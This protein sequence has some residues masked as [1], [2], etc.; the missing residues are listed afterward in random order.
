MNCD[1]I[2]QVNFPIAFFTLCVCIALFYFTRITTSRKHSPNDAHLEKKHE[3]IIQN[4]EEFVQQQYNKCTVES[5]HGNPAHSA[6][7]LN[8]AVSFILRHYLQTEKEVI[9]SNVHKL[10]EESVKL[11]YLPSDSKSK[12]SDSSDASSVL[13][14]FDA[15]DLKLSSRYCNSLLYGLFSPHYK[16]KSL[17]I[18]QLKLRQNSRLNTHI[19]PPVPAEKGVYFSKIELGQCFP[20]IEKIES[21]NLAIENLCFTGSSKSFHM[22]T[23]DQL[24]NEDC[25]AYLFT[26]ALNTDEN[27]CVE[28]SANVPIQDIVAL[29]FSF[30]LN[31]LCCGLTLSLVIAPGQKTN[32][33]LAFGLR[34]NGVPKV[35]F[36]LNTK[37]G[38]A[39]SI[40]NNAKVEALLRSSLSKILSEKHLDPL[41]YLYP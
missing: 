33:P 34:I 21:E 14:T 36:N 38:S 9:C 6:T 16:P 4:I 15:S 10:V 39:Y 5:L 25:I 11:I 8:N 27:F 41:V 28:A 40:E 7:W 12:T 3:L 32:S 22:E 13:H 2:S 19:P 37:I 17:S 29:P 23:I 1:W 18:E 30:Q 31:K 26:I 35:D 24:L 20:F